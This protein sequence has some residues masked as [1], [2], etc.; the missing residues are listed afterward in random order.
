M[1]DTH[2]LA[3]RSFFLTINYRR[4]I[5]NKG[6]LIPS[7][8]ILRNLTLQAFWNIKGGDEEFSKRLK[9]FTF[10]ITILVPWEV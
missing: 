7:I 9:I 8:P 2:F 6:L 4:V 5:K 10:S 3:N 1:P